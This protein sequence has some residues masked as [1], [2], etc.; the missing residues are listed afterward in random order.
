MGMASNTNA[1]ICDHIISSYSKWSSDHNHTYPIPY[2]TSINACKWSVHPNKSC[3]RRRKY[4]EF[5]KMLNYNI[6][7]QTII[8]EIWKI[9]RHREH[10]KTCPET[11]CIMLWCE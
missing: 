1:H 4:L 11:G 5:Q 10:N 9:I 2:V 8:D 7:K 3:K 6:G